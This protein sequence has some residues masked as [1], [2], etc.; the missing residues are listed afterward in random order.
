VSVMNLRTIYDL[1]TP[2]VGVR[3]GFKTRL[4]ALPDTKS[5]TIQ[6]LKDTYGLMT[7]ASWD[8]ALDKIPQ[9][10]REYFT[11]AMLRGEVMGDPRIKISTIHG[12]KGGE[13]ENV[14]I[15]TDMALRTWNEF[16]ENSDDEHR[17]WYVAVTRAKNRLYIIQPKTSMAYDI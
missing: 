2:R 16:Q 6:M 12:V 5:L 4:M 14:V 3:Y 17:V 7:E 9:I 10:E 15:Q 8:I 13:A 11:T 1:M